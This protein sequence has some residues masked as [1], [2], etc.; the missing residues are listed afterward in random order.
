MSRRSLHSR[1]RW[2]PS[3]REG[4]WGFKGFS[5]TLLASVWLACAAC[6]SPD[7]PDE[8][9]ESNEPGVAS[10]GS[11]QDKESTGFNALSTL[12]SSMVGAP[13]RV[14][15]KGKRE[16]EMVVQVSGRNQTLTYREEVG[17]DGQGKF[18]V[19]PTKVIAP[20]LDSDQSQLFLMLQEARDGL[21]YR[22]RDFQV[23]DVE[24][25]L[26]NYDLKIIDGEVVVAGVPCVHFIARR[27][28]GEGLAYDVWVDPK[29]GL[30]LRWEQRD[31]G[32]ELLA[33]VEFVELAYDPEVMEMELRGD[34]FVTTALDP[35]APLAPQIGFEVLDP[36]TAPAGYELV[37]AERFVGPEG[38]VW[39]RR[40]WD[41]GVDRLAFL[42]S[43]PEGGRALAAGPSLGPVD[44]VEAS[45]WSIVLGEL[46]TSRVILLGRVRATE[47][48]DM[49]QSA[50][51][52]R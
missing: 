44:V 43:E 51:P 52:T 8:P 7:E 6:G 49:L 50:L 22:F 48:L 18:K 4:R 36:R 27:M 16:V 34:L 20:R 47:L 14:A 41:D 12:L 42:Q 24:R 38:R 30:V 13:E 25:F 40:V 37:S 28:E 21:V 2:A 15:Y 9:G 33:R 3:R 26:G 23:R 45:A 35:T 10:A 31:G 19:N 32:G 39:L 46:K 29:R 17:A 1:A 5:L 11:P